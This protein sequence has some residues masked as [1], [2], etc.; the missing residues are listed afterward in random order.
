MKHTITTETTVSDEILHTD[1]QR[2]GWHHTEHTTITRHTHTVRHVLAAAGHIL[3]EWGQQMAV[4]QGLLPYNETTMYLSR[5]DKKD[6]SKAVT[7]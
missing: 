1:D 4:A 6:E 2:N 7:S 5:N 3:N